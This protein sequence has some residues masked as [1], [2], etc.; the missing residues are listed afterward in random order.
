[1]KIQNYSTCFFTLKKTIRCK[2][3]NLCTHLIK[4]INNHCVKQWKKIKKKT[5]IEKTKRKI[6]IKISIIAM[7]IIYLI[8]FNEFFYQNKFVLEK[9]IK[10][11]IETDTHRKFVE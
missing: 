10:F 5:E 1:M 8:M 4:Q 6:K 2:L 7:R 11:I 9:H 3:K